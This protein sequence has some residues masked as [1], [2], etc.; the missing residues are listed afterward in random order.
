MVLYCTGCIAT[1]PY[2][3]SPA[4]DKDADKELI[5]QLSPKIREE[6][7]KLKDEDMEM[8][9]KVHWKLRINTALVLVLIGKGYLTS[10]TGMENVHYTKKLRII[11]ILNFCVVHICYACHG[12]YMH[13]TK[14]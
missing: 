12:A 1:P 6:K 8:L 9:F 3:L 13:Y 14:S 10:E 4:S 5:D 7:E 11:N 2:H